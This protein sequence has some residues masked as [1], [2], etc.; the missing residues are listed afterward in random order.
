MRTPPRKATRSALAESD[1]IMKTFD[2]PLDRAS[3]MFGRSPTRLGKSRSWCPVVGE[4]RAGVSLHAAG[5]C[6]PGDADGDQ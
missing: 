5:C 6:K 2:L 1:R 3:N 4:L